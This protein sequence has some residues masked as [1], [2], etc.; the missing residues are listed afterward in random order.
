VTDQD[1][2]SRLWLSGQEG[3][4]ERRGRG[5]RGRWLLGGRGG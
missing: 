2:R 1:Q 4:I 3:A 5:R